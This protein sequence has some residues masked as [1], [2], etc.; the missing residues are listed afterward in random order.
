VVTFAIAFFGTQYVMSSLS[1]TES[2][3]EHA[4]KEINK[5]CPVMLNSEIRLNSTNV[6][7]VDKKAGLL[8]VC[9]LIN[10]DVKDKNFNPEVVE[11]NTKLA[12]QK[13]FETN[14]DLEKVRE[15]DVTIYYECK[16]KNGTSI[17][18]F[19]VTGKNK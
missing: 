19:E 4:S 15:K 16:D 13:D 11:R 9:T 18:G 6:M 14:A 17:L 12:A 8:Y 1:S 5:K 2:I 7:S 10:E 3:L